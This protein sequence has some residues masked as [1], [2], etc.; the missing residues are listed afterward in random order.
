MLRALK[1][2]YYTQFVISDFKC[3]GSIYFSV[4]IRIAAVLHFFVIWATIRQERISEATH[5]EQAAC[6]SA[7]RLLEESRDF[8]RRKRGS[9]TEIP[10]NK[11]LQ[12]QWKLSSC[13]ME[14]HI[15][16]CVLV[17]D[18]AV[19]QKEVHFRHPQRFNWGLR[20]AGNLRF[21]GW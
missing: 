3:F 1:K 14:A 19:A 5:S 17:C 4:G 18:C 11:L 15:N 9:V 16:I 13:I 8:C 12:L 21:V 2:I 20:S 6:N 7:L 10:G